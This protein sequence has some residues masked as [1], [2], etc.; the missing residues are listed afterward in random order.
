[1]LLSTPA[2]E[3]LTAVYGDQPLEVEGRIV[4]RDHSPR[5]QLFNVKRPSKLAIFQHS[6][7][8]FI[9]EARSPSTFPSQENIRQ[10]EAKPAGSPALVVVFGGEHRQDRQ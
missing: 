6:H 7:L 4:K 5:L 10:E 8:D 3:S 1:M 9:N 2:A